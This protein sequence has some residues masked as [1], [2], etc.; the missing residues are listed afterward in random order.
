METR[1]SRIGTTSMNGDMPLDAGLNADD[2]ID[3]RC[4][5][6]E[7]AWRN[8]RRPTISDFIHPEDES[9]REKL[10]CEL[11]LVDVECRRSLGEQPTED[12]YLGEFP[13]FAPQIHATKFQYGSAAFSKSRV[14]GKAALRTSSKQPGSHV[15]H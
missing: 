9:H 1:A 10:F 15:A 11:L 2:R 12:D 5:A 14:K 3:E 6:F 7:S 13:E 8:G 4:D